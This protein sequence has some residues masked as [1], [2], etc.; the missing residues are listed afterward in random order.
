[1]MFYCRRF[2]MSEMSDKLFVSDKQPE[3]GGERVNSTPDMSY[4]QCPIS[5]NAETKH[6]RRHGESS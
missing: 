4:S 3:K 1:M 6:I 2:E 5:R